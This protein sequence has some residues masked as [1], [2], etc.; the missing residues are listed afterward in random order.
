M[1]FLDEERVEQIRRV[2]SQFRAELILITLSLLII[3]ASSALFLITPTQAK[4]PPARVTAAEKLSTKAQ[5]KYVYVDIAGAVLYPDVYKLP[6]NTRLK[7]LIEKAGGYS[8]KAD[9]EQIE[10]TMNM[11]RM[12]TDQ[13]KVY[14]PK[15][16]DGV[17]QV[18]A[19]IEDDPLIHINSASLES[20]NSLAG[21]GDV[22][23]RKIIDGRPYKLLSDLA[24]KKVIGKALFDKIIDQIAL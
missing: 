10:K 13:E 14:I 12:L 3:L 4:T 23:A 2:I 11:S 1:E 9:I 17:V 8:Q 18:V 21:V 19:E 24:T 16:G 15:Q 22:T 7:S 20:L 6:E 5:E